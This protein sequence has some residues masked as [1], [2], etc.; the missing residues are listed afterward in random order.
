MSN[1]KYLPPSF[2]VGPDPVDTVRSRPPVRQSLRSGVT[3]P[4]TSQFSAGHGALPVVVP[5]VAG[6]L[7]P[8]TT[9]LGNFRA[10]STQAR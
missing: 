6:P 7:G 1:R 9:N 10:A 3:L 8:K 2:V 5:C 4:S